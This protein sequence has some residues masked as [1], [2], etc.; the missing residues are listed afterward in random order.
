MLRQ[1]L[2]VGAVGA[3][4]NGGEQALGH[5]LTVLA[6]QPVED[7]ALVGGVLVDEDQAVTLLH[8]DVGL[9]CFTHDLVVG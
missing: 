6:F 3:E 9:Q 2:R 7:H 5:D 1:Q 8:D 4:G